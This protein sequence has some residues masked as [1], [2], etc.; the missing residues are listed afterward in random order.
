MKTATTV[1]NNLKHSYETF[2]YKVTNSWTAEKLTVANSDK[3]FIDFVKKLQ[4]IKLNLEALG[5]SGEMANAACM[6]KIEEKLP[7]LV[8]TGTSLTQYL[9]T[10]TLCINLLRS[11]N[12][13]TDPSS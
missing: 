1:K 9:Q 7:L 2:D 10:T 4:K 6:G 13:K 3:G 8:S 5:Q 11:I 12:F